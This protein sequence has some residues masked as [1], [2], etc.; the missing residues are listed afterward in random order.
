MSEFVGQWHKTEAI[1]HQTVGLVEPERTIVLET[2]CEGD[3]TLMAELRTLLQACEAEQAH[4]DR[5][6]LSNDLP[7]IERIGPYAIDR[8]LGRGGMG[9]VYLAR[10]ADGQYEQQVAIKIIDLPIATES[11][12][13]RFRTERQILASLVHPYIARL[14]DGGVSDFGEPYLAMEYVEGVSIASF[15]K[16]Q[17]LQIPS[18][19]GIFRKVCEAVQ[20]AHQNLIVHRDL[21][22][23][24]ILVASDGTPRLLDFGTAKILM[25]VQADSALDLTRPEMRA[26]TPRYASPEQ[27]LGQPITTASDIYSL[28][29][30][31]H[32]LLTEAHPYELLEFS[33][34]EMV[35]V[36]CNEPPTR[37]GAINPRVDG[38]LDSIVLKALRKEPQE[39]YITVEQFSAD[40]QAYLDGRPVE[41][42]RG[43][44]RYL[45]TKF[46]RR[47]KLPLV[48]ASFVMITLIAG[49][50]G[51]LWQTHIANVERRRAEARSADLRELSTSLLSELDEAL[52]QI[53]GSTGAQKL[54]VSRVLEH[55][56]HMARDVQSD[57][58]AQLDLIDAYVRLGNVQGNR[59]Y[60]N[61]ADSAGALVSLNRAL[62]LAQPL[63]AS[64][65][66]DRAILRAEATVLEAR[67]ETLSDTGD[68]RASASSLQ[69]AV[70]VYDR[71]IQL[72][73][74]TPADIHEAAIANET[75]G[76][77]L[78]EDSGMS[79]AAAGIAA[80]RHALAMN[81]EALREDPKYMA[82]LRGIPL[83]HVH[84]G[85][86]VMD[87]NP[88]EALAEFSLALQL[89]S[90]LPAD[91]L[92]TL[93]QV[94]L[95]AMI[96]RKQAETYVELGK[97]SLATPLFSQARAIFQKLADADK[98]NA[99]AL[100]DMQRITEDE[101]R[102][103][104]YAADPQLAEIP[105]DRRKTL[106]AAVGKL[107]Q[108]AGLIREIIAEAP[109]HDPWKLELASV[110][111]RLAT[112]R[113]GIG[114]PIETADIAASLATLR[115]E[116]ESPKATAGDI[117]LAVNATLRAHAITASDP[118]PAIPWAE[119]GVLL[120]YSRSPGYLLL[121]ARAY[122]ANNQ[123]DRARETARTG[124]N[125]LNSMAPHELPFRLKT[126]LTAES[127]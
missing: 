120:T 17:K 79:D 71:M 86:A 114:M 34:E 11:F 87:T 82:V 81:E 96:L 1:F 113:H 121:L 4:H 27:V 98:R 125:L 43:N 60:Q 88:V 76:N 51:V 9:A 100:A 21:K 103:Y 58:Q 97:Y 124:L 41:A 56:D 85:N 111:I 6:Q 78:A 108:D 42:R 22:P 40:M 104:E 28:G 38:D 33:T 84:L 70:H 107:E 37:P 47:N 64:H 123:P 90:A 92:K 59:Y 127:K 19:I 89:Q 109:S 63:A 75:L 23:D 46:I 10:R 122:A 67:G 45:A 77:E 55:L 91:Q 48:A 53:P 112:V 26:F 31:L 72:P 32:V 12:R 115:Q 2:L 99:G 62:A 74:T 3:Q 66:N 118:G 116:A 15:C 80:Y 35:R 119:H 57:P 36:I 106:M 24:N 50:G 5:A 52:K 65:P 117:D 7:P 16:E 30:L 110:L 101:A 49:I 39:R 13:E 61:V 105:T 93:S 83:M 95:R 126:L 20:F 14:L 73:G 8:L 54:L 68:A 69:D 102:M 94:R 29:V 18:L 25:P 44:I